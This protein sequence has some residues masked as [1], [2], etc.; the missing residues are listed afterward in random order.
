MNIVIRKY[1]ETYVKIEAD[2]I[3]LQ[4]ISDYFSF[5]ADNYQFTPK[6]RAKQWDGK[7]RLYDM[8]KNLFPIGLLFKLHIWLE[9]Q[10][11]EIE[12]LNFDKTNTKAS[13][14][15]I[16][17]FANDVLKF[18]FPLRD[19]QL[20]AVK[21]GLIERKC[22]LLSPTGT[23]KSAIIYTLIRMIQ[24]RNKDFKFLVM[25]PSVGLVDQMVGDFDDYSVKTKPFSAQCQKIFSG[26]TKDISKNVVVSTWQ[27]LQDLS[28]EFFMQ[29]DALIVDECHTGSTDGRVIKKLVEHCSRAKYKIGTTGTIQD[30]KLNE[31]SL[32]A[33]YGKIYQFTQTS[34]EIERGNLC[35]LLI[36]Q[37][38]LKYSDDEAAQLFK[39]KV[40]LKKR[41]NN[42]KYGAALYQCEVNFINKLDYKRNLIE[43]ICKKQ[44]NNILILFKRNSQFGD[45]L[46]KQ[47]QNNLPDRQVFFVNG[48]TD[49][50]SRSEVRKICEKINN[51]II[52]ANY[53]VFSTG[54]NVKNLHHIIFGESIKS[55]ITVFQSIGR[56][57]RL[58]SSKS[59]VNIYDIID[60]LIHKQI[61][62]SIFKHSESRLELY[63]REGFKVKQWSVMTQ[64]FIKENRN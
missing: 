2:I 4:A 42:E 54:V 34:K 63:Q 39:Q 47:L 24:H 49:R 61:K 32:N 40:M 45:K 36:N 8:I 58:H 1:N 20:E 11:F 13:I 46:F 41:L 50:E 38:Q 16:E 60:V 9:K 53:G 35:N 26:F 7:I 27:S 57:L 21:T 12:Y 30:A 51:A 5:F 14:S 25:V 55:K 37:I 15:Q 52:V 31:Y 22:V 62:N 17:N 28:K 64:N 43:S 19:Y 10:G 56:G 33:I 48:Q 3:V 29:F 23:G 6:Y 59:I 44:N 18:P